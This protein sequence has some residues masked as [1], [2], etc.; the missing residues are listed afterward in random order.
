MDMLRCVVS[1]T[2]ENNF[3]EFDITFVFE[4]EFFNDTYLIE[5]DVKSSNVFKNVKYNIEIK[6]TKEL[7]SDEEVK[8]FTEKLV[9]FVRNNNLERKVIIQSFDPRALK[10]V[11]EIDSNIKTSFLIRDKVDDNIIS[12][13]KILRVNIISPDYSLLTKEIVENIHKNGF[14][15][16][17]WTVNDVD[18]FLKLINY[19]Q[20]H[21][22]IHLYHL[23]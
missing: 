1:E 21:F 15:V 10:I 19:H 11:K 13:S 22:H 5:S 7:D 6:T 16:L 17:P 18:S 12:Q 2:I 23:F 3:P 20:I 4:N 8:K 14:E 9:D